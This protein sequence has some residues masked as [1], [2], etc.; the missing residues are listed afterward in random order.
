MNT[1]LFKVDDALA[2]NQERKPAARGRSRGLTAG[3]AVVQLRNKKITV[4][5]YNTIRLSPL[6]YF[7]N[8]TK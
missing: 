6:S 1:S 5:D 7:L 3:K 4:S 8:G 2:R